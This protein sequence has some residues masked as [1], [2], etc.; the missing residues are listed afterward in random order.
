MPDELVVGAGKSILDFGIIGAVAVL[1]M[2]AVVVL[3]L[4]LRSAHN[5]LLQA[6]KEHLEDAKQ[7]AVLGEV[8]KNNM[9]ANTE[10]MKEMLTFM[11]DRAR[12]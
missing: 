1:L 9:A 3:V 6:K 2:A 5:E 12:P 4:W 10:A 11:R 7:W 8:L